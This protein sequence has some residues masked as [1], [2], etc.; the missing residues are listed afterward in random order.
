MMFKPVITQLPAPGTRVIV[1]GL[2][3]TGLSCIRYLHRIGCQL[4]AVDT[5]DQPPCLDY[6]Q[7][8]YPKIVVQCGAHALQTVQQSACDL[9]VLSPGVNPQILMSSSWVPQ[10]PVIGDIELFA[11]AVTA[12]VAAITGTNGKSTVTTLL[13]QM[14]TA[15]GLRVAVGGNLGTPALDLVS[16]QVDLYVLELS[17]FQLEMTTSL[18]ARVATILNLTPDHL[19]RHGDIA[20]YYAAKARLFNQAQHIVVNRDDPQV[21]AL[22]SQFTGQQS[23]FTLT[24]PN[25][26]H[27]WGVDYDQAS[28]VSCA[29]LCRGTERWLPVSE[30][31]LR[32]KVNHANV[33]A[34]FALANVLQ[35][36]EIVCRDVA[37]NFKGLDHR[38]QLVLKHQG[39]QWINDSKGTNPGAT[40]A[41]VESVFADIG[42]QRIILIAGGLSKQADLTILTS[43]LVEVLKAIILIGEEAPRFAAA[44]ADRVPTWLAGQLDRAV[45]IAAQIAVTGDA[46][47]LSP[48]CAS[49]DQFRD[50]RHRGQVFTE[51]VQQVC[52]DR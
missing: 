7:T 42:P 33:L 37:R 39:V 47:L 31:T 19:D 25:Q 14:A 48:A 27:D 36:P 52:R 5:R 28:G 8:H 18:Q 23:G 45:T 38:C 26:S 2:G 43:R 6:I 10:V 32:G 46:V 50:Y 49:F 15:A 20:Q 44:I 40:L 3:V 24:M 1:F 34:A 22:A 16:A 51:K 11:Q 35:I 21:V 12:P 41:A 29:W 4:I 9:L 13:A 30:L 17:S